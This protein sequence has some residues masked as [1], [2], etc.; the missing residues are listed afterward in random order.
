MKILLVDDD[1]G[2][3][4][5]MQLALLMMKHV[6]DAYSDPVE[7]AKSYAGQHYD[8]IITDIYMPVLDG[9]AMAERIR[10]GDPTAKII[11]ISGYPTEWVENETADAA[12]LFLKKP[13]DFFQLK[14]MLD[15]ISVKI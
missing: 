3:L 1:T 4:R 7:A 10:D 13:V 6:C 5:G 8:L 15:D 11:F 9:F 12:S 2:S 14:Q